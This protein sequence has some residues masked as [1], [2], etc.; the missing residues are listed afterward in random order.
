MIR[1][2]HITRML[3][4]ERVSDLRR[5]AELL[6]ARPDRRRQSA[7]AKSG[8]TRAIRQIARPPVLRPVSQV[9]DGHTI[10]P[11]S[12]R[13]G[14]NDLLAGRRGEV[15]LSPTRRMPESVVPRRRVCL[16]ITARGVARLED[17]LREGV[18][19]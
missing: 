7:R 14:G 19:R 6:A 10:E 3:A 1:D 13:Q 18:G 15:T 12:D 11:L 17:Y 8:T 5:V 4:S 2:H 9:D 16:P